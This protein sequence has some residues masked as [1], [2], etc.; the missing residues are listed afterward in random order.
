MLSLIYLCLV[1][2]LIFLEK[3]KYLL[4]DSTKNKIDN[5]DKY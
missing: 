2:L 5:I 3:F 4:F 1:F